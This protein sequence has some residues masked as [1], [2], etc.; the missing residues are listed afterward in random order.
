MTIEN[1]E[2][3]HNWNLIRIDSAISKQNLYLQDFK[4]NKIQM[5]KGFGYLFARLRHIFYSVIDRTGDKNLA[6]EKRQLAALFEKNQR[7]LEADAVKIETSP[8]KI[9]ASPF[10]D[11]NFEARINRITSLLRQF[12]SNAV[13]LDLLVLHS[14][15]KKRFG[16]VPIENGV[17]MPTLKQLK[18]AFAIAK[19][20]QNDFDMS[21]GITRARYARAIQTIM[22]G[23]PA[24]EL[25]M[26]EDDICFTCKELKEAEIFETETEYKDG[27]EWQI[28]DSSLYKGGIDNPPNRTLEGMQAALVGYTDQFFMDFLRGIHATKTVRSEYTSESF[29]MVEDRKVLLSQNEKRMGVF[30]ALRTEF[31]GA[32]KDPKFMKRTRDYN[33]TFVPN[34]GF[35]PNFSHDQCLALIERSF[36]TG[37]RGA[38]Q[39]FQDIWVTDFLKLFTFS[40]ESSDDFSI[41]VDFNNPERREAAIEKYMQINHCTREEAL[42]QLSE[43]NDKN[44]LILSYMSRFNCSRDE[45]QSKLNDFLIFHLLRTC[46]FT[47]QSLMSFNSETDPLLINAGLNPSGSGSEYSYHVYPDVL[48]TKAD[49]VYS[50]PPERISDLPPNVTKDH[51]GMF[52]YILRMAYGG[53]VPSLTGKIEGS[54]VAVEKNIRDKIRVS[55][56][57]AEALDDIIKQLRSKTPEQQARDEGRSF[58]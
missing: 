38:G 48:F 12:N 10:H 14:D 28:K 21:T 40:K 26:P 32:L 2:N 18:A 36:D 39:I 55:P 46:V 19:P 7:L 4:D 47:N 3:T 42:T 49:A 35:P 24:A 23:S 45:A 51:G 33:E 58:G 53:K 25:P 54:K 52:I 22:V 27:L 37:R 13:T 57:A 44:E 56:F 11:K 29:K 20:L 17:P 50:I 15:F 16:E 9:K 8:F 6:V 1:N 43:L 31:L 30:T 5:K 34:F 41:L